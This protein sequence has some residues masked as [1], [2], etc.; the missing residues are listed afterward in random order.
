[1]VEGDFS[2]AL[3]R[4]IV[5]RQVILMGI[6]PAQAQAPRITVSGNQLVTTTQEY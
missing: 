3:Y 6:Q 4:R 2:I 5:D 1:V